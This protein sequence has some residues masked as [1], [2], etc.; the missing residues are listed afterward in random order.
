MAGF[1]ILRAFSFIIHYNRFP[2]ISQ[3]LTNE[4]KLYKIYKTN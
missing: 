1:L 4:K 2:K 3:S